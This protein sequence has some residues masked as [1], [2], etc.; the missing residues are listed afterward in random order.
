MIYRHQSPYYVTNWHLLP[1]INNTSVIDTLSMQAQ[2]VIIL[3][4][5]NSTLIFS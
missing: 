3:G 4:K 2:K 1:G 5:N